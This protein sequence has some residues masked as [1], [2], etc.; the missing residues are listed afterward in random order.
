M[1][2]EA[3]SSSP[4]LQP[5]DFRQEVKDNPQ[6]YNNT[7]NR[8]RPQQQ[9]CHHWVCIN[10]R[11]RDTAMQHLIGHVTSAVLLAIIA[12]MPMILPPSILFG[13]LVLFVQLK[14]RQQQK[15]QRR[16]W[17]TGSNAKPSYPPGKPK[18]RLY[19][20]SATTD[21]TKVLSQRSVLSTFWR[22][23]WMTVT[24]ATNEENA[25]FPP[26]SLHTTKL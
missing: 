14:R 20:T 17:N 8:Q 13:F 23:T 25:I 15:Q 26:S 9:P 3:M 21:Q 7:S 6:L 5:N 12:P 4:M 19:Y 18:T 2:Q 11:G 1:G 10:H 16:V 24:E 22:L